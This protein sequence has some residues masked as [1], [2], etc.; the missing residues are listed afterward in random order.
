MIATIDLG[1]TRT[2]YGLVDAGSLVCCASCESN[3]QGSLEDHLNQVL[4]LLRAMCAR[5][6]IALTECAGLGVLSTGLV[7]NREMRVLSTN[8]KYE[9]ATEFDFQQ[10]ARQCAGLELRLENDARGAL[11][12]EWSSG[13]G[14]GVDNL[15]MVT[16]GTGVG[17]AVLLDG[18]LLTGPHFSAGILGGHILVNSGGRRCTCGAVGC[19]ETEA[20]G[21]ALPILIQAHADYPNSSLQGL[22]TV[23]FREVIEHAEAGDVCAK[24]VLEHCLRYWGEA[25]VS[26]I[27]SFDPE[28]MI[29]GGGIMNAPEWLLDRFKQTVADY[30][31]SKPG[32]VELVKAAHPNDAGLLGAAALFDRRSNAPSPLKRQT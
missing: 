28:R 25:L 9:A 23:G 17:T 2:K 21:W 22:E 31:W 4:E 30:A 5:Q 1:G 14:R 11:L 3:A 24:D 32:Q 10:W 16:F 26:Y 27:H 20:S 7:D 18:Q 29:L 13:A 19:L 15:V 8:G 6:G 12:G